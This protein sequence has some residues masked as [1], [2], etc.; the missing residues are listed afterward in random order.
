MRAPRWS[1]SPWVHATLVALAGAAAYLPS[2]A[3]PFVFDDFSSIRDNDLL[4]R[5]RGVEPLWRFE[6]NRVVT[7]LT[8]RLNYRLGGFDVVGYHAVNLA[9]HVLAGLALFA[10]ARALLR[11][12]RVRASLPEGAGAAVPVLAALVFVLHPLHTQAVTYIVQRLASL[13][14]LFYLAALLAYVR[15]RLAAG[16]PARAGW[17]AAGAAATLLAFHTKESAATLPLAM[18]LVEAAIFAP[19]R[20]RLAWSAAAAVLALAVFAASVALGRGAGLGALDALSRETPD[21][22]RGRYLATQA[23][24]V[25]HYLRLF[26]LPAGLRLDY[27]LPLREGFLDPA[28]A[29][30]AAFHAAILGAA[31]LAGRRRPWLAFAVPFAYLA[32]LVESGPIPIR[33]LAFEHRAYLPG[34]GLALAAA[35]LAAVELPRLR[36]AA[37]VAAPVTLAALVALGAATWRRNREWSDPVAFWRSNAAL[38]P[39]KPRPWAMLGRALLDADRPAEALAALERARALRR[40]ERADSDAAL[41]AINTLWAL[42]RL[43]R[44]DEALRWLERADSLPMDAATRASLRVNEGNLRFDRGEWREAERAFR[45]ALALAPGNLAALGNLASARAQLGDLEDAERLWAEVLRADPG[46]RTVR[47]NLALSRARRALARSEAAEREGR[48]GEARAAALEALAVLERAARDLPGD[49][50]LAAFGEAVRARVRDL[51]ARP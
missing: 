14:A 18:L 5:W 28:V 32:H 19:G 24:V 44:H 17:G 3:V 22:P 40:G 37:R 47:A 36:P 25:L 9:I 2:F 51:P 42:R 23:V 39:A 1:R 16:T 45:E 20:R 49:A 7:Y 8:F 50:S 21:I 30:A 4:Y 12:P 6:P 29:L 10:L 35:W 33:D 46:D 11:A 31:L 13:A 15:A 43:G 27:D 41:D 48:A 38:A 26:V 34:A